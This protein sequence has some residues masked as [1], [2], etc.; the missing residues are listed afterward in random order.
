MLGVDEWVQGNSS[1]AALPLTRQQCSI[2]CESSR[3]A[4][5]DKIGCAVGVAPPSK[6]AEMGDADHS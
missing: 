5:S 3:V 1:R 4:Y 2:H 6:Q